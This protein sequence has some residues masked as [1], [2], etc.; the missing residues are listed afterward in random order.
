MADAISRFL[1]PSRHANRPAQPAMPVDRTAPTRAFLNPVPSPPLA[2]E[3]TFIGDV[4]GWP[5]RLARV[6]AQTK[7]MPVLVGDLIDRGPDVRSVVRRV[8]ELCEAGRA[9]CLL[10][11]HEYALVRALGVPGVPRLSGL[12]EAWVD[13]WGGAAVLRSYGAGDAADLRRSLGDDLDWMASLPWVL[14]GGMDGRRWIAV[15]AGLARDRATAEQLSELRLG[16]AGPAVDRPHALFSKERT[17]ILPD[18][19]PADTCVVSGHTPRLEALV[20]PRR[21]LCDTTGGLVGRVL[22]GVQWPSGRVV[23][24]L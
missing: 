1:L 21:I 19:L 24:S 15:H 23:L 13:G 16:W 7:G 18:D 10:G 20:E 12:F 2:G 5:D 11:N 4:H 6:L 14:E 9:R 22:S 3:V 17:V 8:R